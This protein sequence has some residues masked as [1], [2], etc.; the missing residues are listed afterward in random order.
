MF[1]PTRASGA[2]LLTR[3]TLRLDDALSAISLG[4]LI[5]ALQRVPG[6]LVAEMNAGGDRAFLSH[7]D[8]VPMSSLVAAAA[9]AGIRATIIPDSRARTAPAIAAAP[10]RSPTPRLLTVVGLAVFVVLGLIDALVPAVR[11][12]HVASIAL[13]SSVWIFF[14]VDMYLARKG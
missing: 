11:N 12:N 10:A 6:V 14:L 8:A 3:T 4:N 5:R 9:G 1:D 7:D 2:E 13:I